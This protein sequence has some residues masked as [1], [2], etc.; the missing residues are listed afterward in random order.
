M[1]INYTKKTW[2]KGDYVTPTPLN[3]IETGIKNAC[4]AVDEI[5][6][7][8]KTDGYTSTSS[9]WQGAVL[10]LSKVLTVGQSFSGQVKYGS[11][12]NIVVV[13]T[14][15]TS[16]ISRFMIMATNRIYF[17]RT[18]SATSLTYKE[19]TGGSDTVYP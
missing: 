13:G 9:D 19:L 3:N 1:A 4:D 7:N 11:S 6:S 12:N 14:R 17:A 15:V 18:T 16:S 8:F 5:N 10:D 2:A